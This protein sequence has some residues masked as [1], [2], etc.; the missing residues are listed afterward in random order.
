MFDL[1]RYAPLVLIT[2][3]CSGGTPEMRA[4]EDA[5]DAVGGRR[6]VEATAGLLLEAEGESYYLGESASPGGDLPVFRT[7]FR[8][9]FDWSRSR[10]RK[11]EARTPTFL[12]G[13]QGVRR[14]VTALDGDL[15]FDV[16]ADDKAVPL[17]DRDAR[18]RRAELLHHPVGV[19]RA[20]MQPGA[21]VTNLRQQNAYDVVDVTTADGVTVTLSLDR[22]TKLPARTTSAAAHPFLGDVRVE[23]EFSDYQDAGDLR[24]PRRLVSSLDGRPIARM[25]VASSSVPESLDGPLPASTVTAFTK[26]ARLEAPPVL[27]GS[28]AAPPEPVVLAEE[29]GRGVWY[30]TGGTHH[31]VLVEFADHL[32]LIEAPLDEARTLALLAKA[33]ELRPDKPVTRL[34]VTHHHFDHTGGLRAAVARELTVIAREAGGG[35]AFYEDVVRRPHT[36]V[37]DLLARAPKPLR[38]ESFDAEYVLKDATRVVELYA[39]AGSRYADTLLMAYLPAERLLIEADVFTPADL[40]SRRTIGFPFAANLLENIASRTLNVERVVPLHGRVVPLSDLTDAASLP[41]PAIVQ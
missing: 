16:G 2:A 36:L 20:A 40:R 32:A 14:V 3:A 34:I 31:S 11:E 38:L 25:T 30:L 29:I 28:R 8:Q 9:A 35:K 33:R 27:K 24:L 18:D 22:E 12:A 17:T 37:P 41:V 4:I 26:I 10:F 1:R 19:L 5:I 23:T 39:I 15:A 21:R 6:A 7:R 13:S